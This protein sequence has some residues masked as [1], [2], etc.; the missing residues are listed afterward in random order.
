MILGVM[1]DSHGNLEYAQRV[2]NIMVFK[3]G[4]EAIIHLGDD[5]AD[6]KQLDS[7]GKTV[8]AVP[9]VY[10][11]SWGNKNVSHRLIKEFGGVV[12]L[13]S[14]TPTQDRQ[15]RIGDINPGRALSKYGAQVLL[16]GHTH[17]FGVMKAIDGLIVVCPG[18]IKSEKDRGAFPTFAVVEA[19]YPDVSVRFVSIDGEVLEDETFRVANVVREEIS[20]KPP[21]TSQDGD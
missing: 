8:Y 4:V 20:F 21:D 5:Y 17:R 11:A 19:G 3:F 1:S 10:D 14:H 13:M 7:K 9:G 16:H 18:H 15:D 2:C 12:F 6:A